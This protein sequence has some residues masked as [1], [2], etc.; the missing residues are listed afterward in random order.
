MPVGICRLVALKK[1][2]EK[3]GPW[4]RDICNIHALVMYIHVQYVPVI[5]QEP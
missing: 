3:R 4:K 1:N 2:L 5:T